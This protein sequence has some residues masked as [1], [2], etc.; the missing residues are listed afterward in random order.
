MFKKALSILIFSLLLSTTNSF[1]Q[2]FTLGI[3]GGATSSQ[4][5]GDGI[6]GFAQFGV[7]AGADVRYQ[8]NET[9]SASFGL[10]FNQKG[11]RNYQSKTVYSAYRLRVNYA[12]APITM[13]YHFNKFKFSAGLYLGAKINQRE[14]NSFGPIEP[15]REFKP[16]DF[17]VQVGVNYEMKENWELEMRFQNSLIP[18]RNHKMNQAYPPALFILGDWHQKYLNKGQFFTSLSLVVRRTF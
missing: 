9:W 13:N 10:Q 8:F 4:I 14:R 5:S 6:Y 18:V 17:G 1:S 15:F 16:L 12:E 11:A 2:N 7:L 3:F